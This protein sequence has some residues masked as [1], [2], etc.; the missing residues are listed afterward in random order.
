MRFF[1]LGRLGHLGHHFSP[2]REM[3]AMTSDF[4]YSEGCRGAERI[5]RDHKI[6]DRTR[7]RINIIRAWDG[8]EIALGRR[9]LEKEGR[10]V[11]RRTVYF[12]L[13]GRI[14][15]EHQQEA[16]RQARA[17][18]LAADAAGRA[19]Q[20]AERMRRERKEAE[21]AMKAYRRRHGPIDQAFVILGISPPA[22]REQITKA[23]RKKALE[24]HPDHGGDPA[25]F[26][27]LCEARDQ[28]LALA[29]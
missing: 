22:S 14:A 17:E 20:E 7:Y 3:R 28:A 24:H 9:K 11:D 29:S 16:D 8:A 26:R 10:I 23:F 6:I 18:R 15:F 4:L 1:S 25:Q 13:D 12:T 2:S 21:E 19:R 5:W 27:G